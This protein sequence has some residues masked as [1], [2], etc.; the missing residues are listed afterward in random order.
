M[1]GLC[2]FYAMRAVAREIVLQ[3]AQFD[4]INTANLSP[5][6][7]SHPGYDGRYVVLVLGCLKC[8]GGQGKSSLSGGMLRC[9]N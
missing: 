9:V 8:R 3:R 6:E 7:T 4:C 1:T 5:S 2:I